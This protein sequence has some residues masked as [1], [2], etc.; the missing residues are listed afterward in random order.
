MVPVDNLWSCHSHLGYLRAR[1]Q[2][3][4]Q[5]SAPGSIHSHHRAVIRYREG[6]RA[7]RR[8]AG[9]SRSRVMV[10]GGLGF[11]GSHVVRRLLETG[12]EDVVVV[13]D[14]SLGVPENLGPAAAE[15]TI[16]PID[17]RDWTNVVEAI[18]THR[19]EVVIH[20]AAIHFIP[21]CD[22][23]PKRCVDVNV[24]GTQ[25]VLDGCREAE[26]KAV[27]LASTAAVYAPTHGLTA[28]RR[29]SARRTSTGSASSSPSSSASC[30]TSGRTSPCGWR[31]CSTSS[32]RARR[33]LT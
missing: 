25:A 11:V 19:P 14:C 1:Y 9:L 7:D 20:L 12:R 5:N 17:V 31:A 33:T 10:T 23:D 26:V 27:V 6:S 13:D 32:G 8:S 16:L 29:G 21:A 30:S 22:A 3:F 28:S 24:G 4:G 18:G 2:G 15:V